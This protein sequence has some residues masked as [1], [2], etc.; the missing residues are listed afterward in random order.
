MTCLKIGIVL[1]N[2]YVI[3]Q[4]NWFNTNPKIGNT[5]THVLIVI[6]LIH[7]NALFCKHELQNKHNA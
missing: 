3:T 6:I 2:Y 4:E 7:V 5:N 1:S